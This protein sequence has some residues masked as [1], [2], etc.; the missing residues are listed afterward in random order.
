MQRLIDALDTGDPARVT[1]LFAEAGPGVEAIAD[2]AGEL[3]IDAWRLQSAEPGPPRILTYQ[4]EA[5]LGDRGLAG[6]L[7][8]SVNPD[9]TPRTIESVRLSYR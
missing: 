6:P 9:G 7:V 3:A 4:L 1:S 8:I 2:L 5:T